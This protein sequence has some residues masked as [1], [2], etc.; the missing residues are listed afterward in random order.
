MGINS[1]NL[2]NLYT[3]LLKLC[4]KS[5]IVEYFI[6]VMLISF[7]TTIME[8]IQCNSNLEKRAK[9]RVLFCSSNQVPN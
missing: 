3:L 7:I 6:D 4:L 1:N 2:Y 9:I 8:C 5:N